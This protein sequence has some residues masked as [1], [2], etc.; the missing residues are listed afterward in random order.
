MLWLFQDQTGRTFEALLLALSPTR[1]RLV[2]PEFTDSVEM[3]Y[4]YGYW[5]AEDGRQL[6][7]CGLIADEQTA[8]LLPNLV[9]SV[10]GVLRS[11]GS[12]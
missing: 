12:F 8:R 6:E 4:K 7:F 5:T 1:M 3:E 11:A 9:G 2:I 10:N